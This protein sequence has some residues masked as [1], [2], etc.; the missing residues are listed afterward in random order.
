[1]KAIL[2]RSSTELQE[3]IGLLAEFISRH[4]KSADQAARADSTAYSELIGIAGRWAEVLLA[5]SSSNRSQLASLAMAI[6]R[7]SAP[8]LVPVLGRMLAEDLTRWRRAREEMMRA[9]K[10]GA[11]LD[12]QVRSSAQ[13]GHSLQYRHAFS[14]IGGNEVVEL[15]KG[16]LPAIGFD[17]FGVDAAHVL[18]EI[19][20]REHASGGEKR[21]VFGTDF[22]GVS[23]LRAEREK[24]GGG[25]S[26]PF[27]DAIF[28]VI[29]DLIKPGSSEENYRHALQLAV[30]GFSMPHGDRER[31][32]EALLQLP[33]SLRERQTLLRALVLAGE[34]VSADMLL[35]GLRGLLDEAK[36]KGRWLWDQNSWWEV[37]GWLDL[38][39]FSDRPMATLD[40]LEMI[41]ANGRPWGLRSVLAALAY[42]PSSEAEDALKALG[43]KEPTSCKDTIG[44]APWSAAVP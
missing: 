26:S 19:W 33:Q 42:A 13:M 2:E 28:A 9:N 25:A 4:G 30:V 35:D 32:K 12:P 16:Y 18:K 1:M 29:D 10:T 17:A 3:E 38:L 36:S 44:S 8:E 27:A 43:R 22:S 31:I 14:V 39:P 24:P 34:I 5:S 23:A 15:M 37:E 11:K 40:G 21:I 41:E 7:L 6:G 20:D